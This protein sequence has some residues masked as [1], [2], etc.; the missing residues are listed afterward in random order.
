MKM[1]M[2]PGYRSLFGE[3]NFTYKELLK[4]VSSE[5]VIMILGSINA[6]LNT[7][8]KPEEKHSRIWA[9]ISY[10][11][12]QEHLKKFNVAFTKFGL[13]VNGF[14]GRLFDR[15]C[16]LAMILNE[17]QRNNIC[18]DNLNDPSGEYDFVMAY[19]LVVD[20]ERKRDSLL[21]KE[22]KDIKDDLMPT[23]PLLWASSIR[24]YEFN[25]TGNTAFELFKLLSFS[26]YALDNFRPYMKELIQKNS[27]KNLSEYI[28]S[29]FQL[30]N[31]TLID[32]ADEPLRKLVYIVPENDSITSHLQNLCCNVLIG[33]QDIVMSDL[34]KYP[35][36]QTFKGFMILDENM[37]R[38]KIYRGALFGLQKE[39]ELCK[40]MNFLDYKTMVSKNFIEKIFF[41][42]ICSMMIKTKHDKIYFD[43][44]RIKCPDLFYRSDKSVIL[45]EFKDY[46]FPDRVMAGNKYFIFKKYLEERFVKS[47]KLKPK[48]I[49]QLLKNISEL[50]NLELGFDNGLNNMIEK[51]NKIKV[52]PI[53]CHTDLMFSMPGVNEYLNIIFSKKIK[54]KKTESFHVQNVTIISQ[55]VLFDCAARGETFISLMKLI[56]RYWQIVTNLK[57]NINSVNGFLNTVISFDEVYE[58]KFK[59][60]F[61]KKQKITTTENIIKMGELVGLTE[62][63]FFEAL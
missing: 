40:V 10:R 2:T 20:E 44:G 36:Y 38:K 26:K 57:K 14:T 11:F 27:F 15:S 3:P 32:N 4:K 55:E 56:D 54:E 30:S 53:I 47:E 37:F 50:I 16:L 49:D 17:L 29:F 7:S 39:T 12:S 46:L 51:G 42:N 18:E 21:M 1:I 48:G 41:R 62:Q 59:G 31:V 33:K 45:L 63:E 23:M 34:R 35:L 60:E 5:L 52:Y 6:E 9:R 24:Q 8:E 58:T 25:H 43:D 19:L 13:D 28:T 61:I 22:I